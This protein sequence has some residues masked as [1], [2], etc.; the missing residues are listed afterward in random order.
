M[1]ASVSMDARTRVSPFLPTADHSQQP[2]LALLA[3]RGRPRER[4]MP[5]H[6]PDDAPRSLDLDS[7]DYLLD[8]NLRPSCEPSPALDLSMPPWPIATTQTPSVPPPRPSAAADAPIVERAAFNSE[9]IRL[10]PEGLALLDQLAR[11]FLPPPP[12]RSDSLKTNAPVAAGNAKMHTPSLAR[13]RQLGPPA[14]PHPARSPF[15]PPPPP[16]SSPDA[17]S[18]FFFDTELTR[19]LRIQDTPSSSTQIQIAES[20]RDQTEDKVA[21]ARTPAN[22]TASA[23]SNARKQSP[24][25]GSVPPG[26]PG[27]TREPQVR[28]K[29]SPRLASPV[30]DGP[31]ASTS[32]ESPSPAGSP[33]PQ[34]VSRRAAKKRERD[35]LRAATWRAVYRPTGVVSVSALANPLL[36]GL[37]ISVSARFVDPPPKTSANIT[38]PPPSQPK[39]R[40][41]QRR[42]A[43]HPGQTPSLATTPPL[44]TSRIPLP[45]FLALT[46]LPTP[47][48]SPTSRAS[49]ANELVTSVMPSLPPGSSPAPVR[50]TT[51]RQRSEAVAG[52][53]RDWHRRQ[54][55]FY[56][57]VGESNGKKVELPGRMGTGGEDEVRKGMPTWLR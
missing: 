6:P 52:S 19:P 16:I 24:P 43:G 7:F 23:V 35:S 54:V 15:T 34:N 56:A 57:V 10:S 49:S 40:T 21:S 36:Q 20:K 18:T 41:W 26:A 17:T 8:P 44:P 27:R 28:P 5:L 32:L 14:Q 13:L 37:S 50:A 11:D 30:E 51:A 33:P 48:P 38:P 9:R 46:P 53:D 25:S 22:P 47:S 2:P 1:P 39:E 12:K 3:P 31:V 29:Q 42:Q 55:K 45:A 4:T